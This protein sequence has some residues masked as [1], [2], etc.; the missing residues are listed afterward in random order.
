[1]QQK[2]AKIAYF[3]KNILRNFCAFYLLIVKSGS[4]AQRIRR[5]ESTTFKTVDSSA[6]LN[7]L[8]VFSK[9]Q[10]NDAFLQ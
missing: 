1:M 3:Q 2:Y 4:Y 10:R 6:V 9:L 5:A 8:K 7:F